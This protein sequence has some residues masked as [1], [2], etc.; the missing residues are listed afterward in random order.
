[1]GSKLNNAKNSVCSDEGM[2]IQMLS[3]HKEYPMN[4]SLIW[5]IPYAFPQFNASLEM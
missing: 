3:D 4:A 5:G 1:V 2:T